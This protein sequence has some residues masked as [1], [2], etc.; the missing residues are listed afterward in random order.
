MG[1][2]GV[3][4]LNPTSG[5]IWVLLHLLP[6]AATQV[7]WAGRF[8]CCG[9]HGHWC[10]P[11]WHGGHSPPFRP[12]EGS[13]GWS[14]LDGLRGRSGRARVPRLSRGRADHASQTPNLLCGAISEK[15]L[16][17]GFYLFT[18]Y[19]YFAFV[20][21]VCL[22]KIGLISLCEFHLDRVTKTQPCIQ[23]G[24]LGRTTLNFIRHLLLGVMLLGLNKKPPLK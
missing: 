18:L 8:V 24:P 12:P 7:T 21:R 13:Q 11:S 1:G 19:I 2:V 22:V 9:G 4:A 3:S 16:T 14:R 6:R 10:R 20:E 5:T 15:M 17:S 23:W